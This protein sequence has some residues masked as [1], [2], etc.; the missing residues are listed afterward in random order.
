MVSLQNK[1]ACLVGLRQ[2]Q[3]KNCCLFCY[4]CVCYLQREIVWGEFSRR[5]SIFPHNIGSPGSQLRSLRWTFVLIFSWF[6][7]TRINKH[8]QNAFFPSIVRKVSDL[9]F[10]VHKHIYQKTF[11]FLRFG[12]KSSESLLR[13]TSV[14]CSLYYVLKHHIVWSSE[15]YVIKRES[16]T[17]KVA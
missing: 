16:I 2:P 7:S 9:L 6:S 10:T 12:T 13:R 17:R 15:A 8:D 5:Y 1:S 3:Q 4:I 11:N 14:M